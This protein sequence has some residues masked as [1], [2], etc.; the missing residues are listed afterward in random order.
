MSSR[1][2]ALGRGE[3]VMVVS[4]ILMA[5]ALSAVDQTVVTTA[6]PAIA[7]ELHG[8]TQLSWIVSAYLLTSTPLSLVYGKL[9]DL[10]GRRRLILIAIV[11]FVAASL[12]CGFA[13]S[14]PQ[15]IAGRALQGLGAGGLV[16]TAQ[17]MMADLVSPRER[18]RYQV[19]IIGMFVMSSAL[20]PLLGGFFVDNWSW[21]WVFWVN[22]PIGIIAFLICNRFPALHV[23]RELRGLDYFGLA[24]LSI[25]VTALL[26]LCS[27]EESR[28][29]DLRSP[30]TLAEAVVFAGFLA[31]FVRRELR[32]ENP[33][34]PVR[35]LRNAVVVVGTSAGFLISMLMFASMVLLPVFLQEVSGVSAGSSGALLA[36]ML[37][38]MGM[39][40][41][42]TS[43]IMRRTGRYK[44][45][46]PLMF[47]LVT[48]AMLLLSTMTTQTAPLRVG[49]YLLLLGF[50][51]G[52]GVPIVNVSVQNS[53]DPQDL[54]IAISTVNFTRSLGGAF[55][56][57][58]F[59]S[60]LRNFLGA[61]LASASPLALQHAFHLVFLAAAGAGV[62]AVIL[63][64]ILR[65]EPLKTTRPA[66]RVATT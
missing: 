27:G 64:L 51:L 24:L 9:S 55:G 17:A 1:P 36:P 39:A 46:L 12:L 13:Q 10:Y 28:S 6:M 38:G 4:G 33:V 23:Q 20:G 16:V 8:I 30:E 3:I 37:A 52:G 2:I 22:L 26:L 43:Q 56:A 34:F 62:L 63:G 32:A 21:R 61:P 7:R 29:I 54:G 5:V 50:G 66:D 53:A 59:W 35:L 11:I 18:A 65:E 44:I 48:A 57:V 49:F 41:I 42:T 45:F 19:Y 47:S 40:S 60:L 31:A 58:I 15:L 25:W 14:I